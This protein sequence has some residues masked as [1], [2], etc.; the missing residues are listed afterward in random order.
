L[1]LVAGELEVDRP[2]RAGHGHTKGLTDQIGNPPDVIDGGV[3]L[4]DGVEGRQVIDLLVDPPEL[5]TGVPATG[6][7][8]HRRMSEMGIAQPG[9]EVLGADYLGHA[10]ARPSGGAGVTV[11]H[12]GGRFL[13]VGP[14]ALDP[15]SCL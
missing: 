11:G 7:G 1:A 14:D 6:E 13:P 9:G 2:W 8:D 5:G 15:G 3:E 12:V 10:N 4:G